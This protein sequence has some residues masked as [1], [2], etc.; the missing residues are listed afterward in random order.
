MYCL[1]EVEKMTVMPLLQNLGIVLLEQQFTLWRFKKITTLNQYVKEH[2]YLIPHYKGEECVVTGDPEPIHAI[3]VLREPYDW[4]LALQVLTDLLRSEDGLI[5]RD[6]FKVTNEQKM[7]LFFANPDF[8]YAANYPVSRMTSGAFCVCLEQIYHKY[9]GHD[10]AY[11]LYGK[12]M[13][14]T[15]AYVEKFLEE[16]YGSLP[17]KIFAIGDNPLSDIK[18]A[19]AAGSIWRSILVRT[20]CFKGGDNDVHNPAHY[21]TQDL[22]G[23]SRLIVSLLNKPDLA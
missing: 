10:L 2:P 23:A 5:T 12:P 14:T 8:D 21:V 16:K 6:H 9:T 19:N 13:S 11:T 1:L 4:F 7:P 15:Y 22:L 17:E 20:G 3:F 18:G